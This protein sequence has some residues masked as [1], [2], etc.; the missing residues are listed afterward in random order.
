MYG[1]KPTAAERPR[2]TRFASVPVGESVASELTFREHVLF[3]YLNKEFIEI[4][5]LIYSISYKENRI[6]DYFPASSSSPFA[7]FL[8]TIVCLTILYFE[9]YALLQ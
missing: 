4:I 5:L 3:L 6:K 9:R 2:V 1:K 7:R 8:K